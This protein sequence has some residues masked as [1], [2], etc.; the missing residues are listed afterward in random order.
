M[1]F[2]VV[3]WAFT[4]FAIDFAIEFGFFDADRGRVNERRRPRRLLAESVTGRALGL[5]GARTAWSDIGVVVVCVWVDGWWME[6]R[7]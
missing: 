4:L 6:M 1:S 7:N 5:G 3:A 2:V